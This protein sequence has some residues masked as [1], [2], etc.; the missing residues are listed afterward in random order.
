MPTDRAAPLPHQCGRE[1]L[2]H[3]PNVVQLRLS[4][5]SPVVAHGIAAVDDDGWVT[6]AA[7]D[8][9]PI[10]RWTHDPDRL[11]ADLP[12]GCGE[13]GLGVQGILAVPP[14]GAPAISG[15]AKTPPAFPASRPRVPPPPAPRT[16]GVQ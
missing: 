12:A 9:D 11:G 5:E 2:G 10:K 15:V 6:I 1:A 16:P 4:R 13:G 3:E 14:P 7:S 8:G